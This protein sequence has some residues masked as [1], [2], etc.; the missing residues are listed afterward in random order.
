[1]SEKTKALVPT[2]APTA[3]G[4][5]VVLT[6]FDDHSRFARAAALAQMAGPAHTKDT[7]DTATAC[8]FMRIQFGAE[9]GFGPMSSLANVHLIEQ[10]G[11]GVKPSPSAAMIAAR[12]I[13]TGNG[14]S[15]VELSSEAC[16]L[17]FGAGPNGNPRMSRFTLEDAKTA[18]LR[19][20]SFG[21][22]GKPG[23]PTN[24][25]KFPRNMLFAR[26]L[27]NGAKWY[28]PEMFGGAVYT[29][30]EIS[31]GIA[32]EDAPLPAIVVASED[33]PTDP[34]MVEAQSVSEKQETKSE[35]Q[36]KETKAGAAIRLFKKVGVCQEQLEG[37]GGADKPAAEWTDSDFADLKGKLGTIRAT[38][39]SARPTVI[40]DIFGL[41]GSSE[42]PEREP[43]ME[44]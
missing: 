36:D 32:A 24:W 39:F 18:G 13:A 29:P 9:L 7:I 16:E 34:I 3:I 31:T 25:S 5:G 4:S 30:D 19:F 6:T 35:P 41:T 1:M 33:A 42:P 26:A 15:V 23:K 8:A 12:L 22:N 44:G 11:G 17:D 38:E 27:T 43:G 40:K 2:Q 28:H 14:Y 20:T 10:P 37:I 21:K